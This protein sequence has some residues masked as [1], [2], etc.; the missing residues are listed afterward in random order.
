[1]L[2]TVQWQGSRSVQLATNFKL[3]K[4][5]LLGRRPFRGGVCVGIWW[6]EGGGSRQTDQ[7]WIDPGLIWE[8]EEAGRLAVPGVYQPRHLQQAE[9]ERPG[10]G[11][12]GVCAAEPR[13]VLPWVRRC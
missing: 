1:M 5:Y 6:W 9:R 13:N 11:G 3:L 8:F 2:L 7:S 12:D 10:F 4:I